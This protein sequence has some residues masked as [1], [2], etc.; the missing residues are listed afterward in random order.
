MGVPSTTILMLLK[1]MKT[2]YYAA[3]LQGRAYQEMCC[4]TLAEIRT[5]KHSK[6]LPKKSKTK[7]PAHDKGRSVYG[8]I[9]AQ[10]N[11]PV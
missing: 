5:R 3:F 2:W 11:I 8:G 10:P 4:H 1:I 6:E 7:A 9:E